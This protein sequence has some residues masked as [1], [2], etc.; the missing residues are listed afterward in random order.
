MSV[1]GDAGLERH[2]RFGKGLARHG[3]EEEIADSYRAHDRAD[4]ASVGGHVRFAIRAHHAVHADFAGG[5]QTHQYGIFGRLF[6]DGFGGRDRAV[7]FH[8]EG[9][10][11]ECEPRDG[12]AVGLGG[13]WTAGADRL[14]VGQGASD[15]GDHHERRRAWVSFLDG[16]QS[17]SGPIRRN[18]RIV[19]AERGDV[20]AEINQRRERRAVGT[21]REYHAQFRVDRIARQQA[22][23][24]MGRRGVNLAGVQRR[25]PFGAHTGFDCGDSLVS[26]EVQV[27]LRQTAPYSDVVGARVIVSAGDDYRAC[28]D[29]GGF[30]DAAANVRGAV[31]RVVP[32]VGEEMALRI[33][34]AK[35]DGLV[36]ARDC[37]CARVDR[38]HHPGRSPD[39]A[40]AV[41]AEIDR[42]GRSDFAPRCADAIFA[43]RFG[44]GTGRRHLRVRDRR[45][46]AEEKR[47]CGG[48]NPSRDI[49]RSAHHQCHADYP[50][51]AAGETAG[52]L[53]QLARC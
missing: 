37:D 24:E 30:R 16:F 43:A 3:G 29:A 42:R 49:S 7:N 38:A 46:R 25:G 47:R 33:D 20:G 53:I 13:R 5:H 21:S 39:G 40:E 50:T 14:E 36:T 28:G 1:R 10:G 31:R 8:R 15:R 32:L 41:A 26:D 18:L 34:R 48:D 19:L 45:E 52:R 35:D 44:G 27:G 2:L 23:Q 11:N 51:A 12:R 17:R 6:E 22:P 9:L 4:L